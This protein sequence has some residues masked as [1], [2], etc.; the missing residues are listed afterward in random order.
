MIF[1]LWM[2]ANQCALWWADISE[3]HRLSNIPWQGCVS[4]MD[5]ANG[6]SSLFI[7]QEMRRGPWVF[8][9]WAI[10]QEWHLS[11]CSWWVE[12]S[13]C[14]CFLVCFFVFPLRLEGSLKYPGLVDSPAQAHQG[15]RAGTPADSLSL[16]Q[17]SWN[18]PSAICIAF[19]RCVPLPLAWPA[20]HPMVSCR[21]PVA[22][23]T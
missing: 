21:H 14:H 20:F 5:H 13:R 2:Q 10:H 15:S 18:V 16:S 4:V 12:A 23:S 8:H 11:S 6:W 19:G 22:C 1:I 7:P 9:S 17:S 3:K